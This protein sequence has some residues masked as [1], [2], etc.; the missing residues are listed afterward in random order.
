MGP[1]VVLLSNRYPN[2]LNPQSGWF[3]AR[4]ADYHRQAGWRITVLAP[5]GG[6]GRLRQGLAY[7]RVVLG[8]AGLL[9]RGRFDL[10]HAHYPFPAGLIGLALSWLRR[11]PLVITSHGY[12]VS[13]HSQLGWL[14]RWA[15]RLVLRRA[16]QI[17]AVSQS[18][19]Q[20]VAAVAGRDLFERSVCI[21]MGVWL[22]A[23]IPDR[24]TARRLVGIATETPLIVFVG[25]LIPRKGVDLLLTAAAT[26]QA[27]D[28]AFQLVI[29]GAGEEAE[30]LRQQTVALGLAGR[31]HFLGLTPHAV[32]YT[33]LAAADITVV[34]S[35]AEPF[36]LTALEAMACGAAV[37]AANVGGLRQTVEPEYNGLLF[38]AGDAADLTTCLEALLQDAEKRQRLAAA[39]RRTAA[40]YDMRHKAAAVAEIYQRLLG[41]EATPGAW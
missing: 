17:I 2:A 39:G 13:N 16:D 31:V 22:P 36:G 15:T 9:L 1:T 37:V 38:A 34:P 25:Y 41:W 4:H 14:A 29:A 32:V 24:P 11:K 5:G 26:L 40:A 19:Q 35:R 6:R 33:W 20:E 3:V 8:A 23:E 28:H 21:D 12:Y 7:G 30:R 27:R 18:H 10:V